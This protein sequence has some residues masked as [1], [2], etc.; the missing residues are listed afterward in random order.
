MAINKKLIHFNSKDNFSNEVANGNILDTSIVFIKDSKEIYTHGNLY[1]SVNWSVLE[2]PLIVFYIR[3]VEYTA[4]EN[5]T[6]GQWIDSKYNNFCIRDG[7]IFKFTNGGGFSNFTI[8]ESTMLING[9][10]I[11]WEK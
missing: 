10:T 3:G 8:S 9:M 4:E 5:M 7:N 11:D 2:K 1:K 6:L